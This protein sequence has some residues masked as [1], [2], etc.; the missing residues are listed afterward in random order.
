MTKIQRYEMNHKGLPEPDDNG[1]W[2]FREDHAAVVAEL[3]EQVHST[4][5][6]YNKQLCALLPDARY[7]DPPDGGGVTPMEQVTRMVIDIQ[8]QVQKLAA[9]N[10][11]LA[12]NV[13]LKKCCEPTEYELK[14][15]RE[16]DYTPEELWGVDGR[17][18]CPKCAGSKS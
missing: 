5:D 11:V 16:G 1:V 9:E 10:T 6:D 13:A 17:K 4:H 2:V 12:E 7:M 14:L 18:S 3:Q 15:L 8:E